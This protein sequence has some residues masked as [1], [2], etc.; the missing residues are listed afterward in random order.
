MGPYEHGQNEFPVYPGMYP[1]PAG[2][3]D[4]IRTEGGMLYPG[5]G[6]PAFDQPNP[7][8]RM[9]VFERGPMLH[10]NG[11]GFGPSMF[12]QQS[13]MPF[14]GSPPV[15]AGFQGD[16]FELP[17]HCYNFPDSWYAD[18]ALGH[19]LAARDR[20]FDGIYGPFSGG[21]GPLGP[22]YGPFGGGH[23][24]CPSAGPGGGPSLPFGFP[25]NA[26][27]ESW[28]P[29]GAGRRGCSPSPGFIFAEDGVPI[30]GSR[31]SRPD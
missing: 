24:P 11:P 10:D 26:S 14:G 13:G 31:G 9:P 3:P 2:G 16:A 19:A 4:I 5:G 17:E 6:P 28:G 21:L 18:R 30:P 23:G 12:G 8:E 20:P 25:D 1:N 22:G 29:V 15:G 27:V 7:F